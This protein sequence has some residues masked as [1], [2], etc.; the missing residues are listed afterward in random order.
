MEKGCRNNFK[1]RLHENRLICTFEPTADNKILYSLQHKKTTSLLSCQQAR[2][3]G[4]RR[5]VTP[6]PATFGA[7]LSLKIIQYIKMRHSEKKDLKIFS[8]KKPRENVSSGPAVALDVSASQQWAMSG[9]VRRQSRRFEKF[10]IFRLLECIRCSL[11]QL[12]RFYFAQRGA[13]KKRGALGHGLSGLCIIPALIAV[14]AYCSLIA[15]I[16]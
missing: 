6:G 12:S 11:T 3:K 1:N 16:L 13:P 4:G 2:R 14:L 15:H 7:P 5:V 9:K 8:A 10:L